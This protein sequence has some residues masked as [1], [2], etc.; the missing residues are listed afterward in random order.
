MKLGSYEFE[1]VPDEMDI[2]RPEKTTAVQ[3]NFGN[4]GFFSWGPQL[5]GKEVKMKWRFTSIAQYEALKAMF[6]A[7]GTHVLDLTPETMF[8]SEGG[9]AAYQWPDPNP[10]PAP[11]YE[12]TPGGPTYRRFYISPVRNAPWANII[13]YPYVLQYEMTPIGGDWPLVD[14]GKAKLLNVSDPLNSYIEMD[15][16]GSD[17][18]PTWQ[19]GAILIDDLWNATAIVLP[20]DADVRQYYIYPDPPL[21]TTKIYYDKPSALIHQEK[22]YPEVA[23]AG[24]FPYEV[25]AVTPTRIANL[26]SSDNGYSILTECGEDEHGTWIMVRP[27][28]G[29]S[30]VRVCGAEYMNSYHGSWKDFV[31]VP[32]GP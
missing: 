24:S 10:Y 23:G 9:D 13:T 12:G 20:W 8:V 32:W 7:G 31:V 15:Q 6:L 19:T 26:Y 29:F 5:I 14:H 30:Q 27:A 25:D 16:Y 28:P 17:G 4:V 11:G 22:W 1:W 18:L 3:P 2:P 21:T